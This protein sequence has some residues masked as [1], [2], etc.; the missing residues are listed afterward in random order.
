MTGLDKKISSLR[1]RIES[2]GSLAVAFSG[3]VD[4]TLLLKLAHD[5]LGD[6]AIAVT[7]CLRSVP[8]AELAEIRLFCRKEQICLLECSIDELSLPEFAENTSERCYFCKREI[9]TELKAA[10]AGE[11]IETVAEGSNTDDLD[12]YRPGRRALSQLGIIS[13]LLDAKFSKAEIR[14]AAKEM[15]L[16]V[17]DK[18][19]YACLASR[20][21][22]GEEITEQKLRMIEA[23]EAVLIS[24]GIRQMRVR[25]H[26]GNMA[27]IEA[28]PEDIERLAGTQLREKISSEFKK[29]GFRYVALDLVG[30][31]KGN[32]N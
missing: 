28:L 24:L 7:A 30:Y 25:M 14:Q 22:T 12:D 26:G 29:I 8:S 16:F 1:E 10:A 31:K 13:P 15:G 9:M 27:R 32:M 21:P 23:A 3:G 19:A 18:P 17:W 20:I 4:S 6:R 11:G 2:L 5:V